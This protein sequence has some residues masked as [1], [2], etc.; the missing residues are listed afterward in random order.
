MKVCIVILSADTGNSTVVMNRCE[1][2]E[3]LTTMLSYSTYRRLKK[4]PTAKIERQVTKALRESEDRG[5]L[6]KE[7]RL[8][9]TP[10][11]SVAPQLY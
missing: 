9:L 10:H 8:L 2:D 6:P 3:K 5:Q 11:A 1:Y 7:R 4:D